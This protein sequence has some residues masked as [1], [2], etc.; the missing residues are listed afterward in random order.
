MNRNTVKTLLSDL[1]KQNWQQFCDDCGIS[2]SNMLRMMINKVT[3]DTGCDDDFKEVK[4]D[5]VTIRFTNKLLKR[6]S[7][8]AKSEGYLSQSNWIRASVMANIFREPVLSQDEVQALRES[9]RYL[10]AIGRNLNQMTRVL[11]IDFRQSNK[12]NREFIEELNRR[13]ENHKDEVS[14]LIDKNCRRWEIEDDEQ[15]AA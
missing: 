11:N 3:P 7:H 14:K 2:Q 4:T 13:I 10:A 5:H 1:E 6:I 12:V 15:G 9:N 8:Q